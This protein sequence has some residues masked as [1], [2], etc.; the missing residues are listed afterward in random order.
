MN[1]VMSRFSDSTFY[2]GERLAQVL[3]GL[4]KQVEA[5]LQRMQATPAQSIHALRRRLKKMQSILQLVRS[6]TSSTLRK[7]LRRH[8]H[9]LKD[10]F[11]TQRDREVR[12]RL[13]E[14]IASPALADCLQQQQ[15]SGQ[16]ELM[17][18]TSH[19][20]GAAKL[21]RL[22][23]SPE[24][25]SGTRATIRKAHQRSYRRAR[26]AWLTA[27]AASTPEH[28][29]AWR[30]RVKS[31]YYQTLLLQHR[32]GR[33]RKQLHRLHQLGHWLGLDH[34]LYLLNLWMTQSPKQPCFARVQSKIGRWQKKQLGQIFKAGEVLFQD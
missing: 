6:Q 26:A 31:F 24:L 17:P 3:Q 28:L 9:A 34:D 18:L 19:K 29:H 27:L 4:A 25:A 33:Q 1:Y 22:L 11:A 15:L 14:K 7:Q 16:L 32:R 21:S 13:A 20:A 23:Q 30:K 10:A 12:I 8:L 5:D 2:Q